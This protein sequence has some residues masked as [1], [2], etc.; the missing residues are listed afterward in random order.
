MTTNPTATWN[1]QNEWKTVVLMSLGFGLVGI[2]RF[3]LLPM[4]PV[5]AK[6]LGL[7]Y[8]D[9]GIIAGAL[10]VTW[11][12]TAIFIG[13][14]A[15]RFGRRKV[16]IY[17]LIVFSVLVGLSG[18]AAGAGSL[19]VLRAVMGFAEGAYAPA[20]I[21]ATLEASKPS[22]HG[23]NLGFQQ[24]A[25][26]LLGLG[27]APIVVTQLLH[28]VDWRWIF[29]LVALPGFLL[30]YLVFKVLRD[31]DPKELALHTATHDANEH[32]WTDVLK[33]RNIPL[34]MIGMLCWLTVLMVT[35]A[36][37]PNYLTDYLHLEVQ[38]MGF[39]LSAIGVGAAVGTVVM[40]ALSD[41]IGRKPVMVISVLCALL[42]LWLL[43]G[44]GPEPGKLFFYLFMTNFFN[45]ACICLTVGPI[46]AESVPVKLMA[47]GSGLVIGVGELFGGAVMPSLAGFVAKH[48][49]IQY[50]MD[51][52]LGGLAVGLIVA[53]SL[54][55]TAP[56]RTRRAAV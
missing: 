4:F 18:L 33:Y 23:M 32:K 14:I 8:Q 28:V 9:M 49:G 43:K 30:A 26:P 47:T 40:P 22:R 44:T 31:H 27:L 48:Y 45:F 52:A 5:I 10:A 54:K 2:D 7:D 15:D 12:L 37:L 25:L 19:I 42:F 35:T 29:V 53:L 51:L 11:G 17:A 34:M 24:A 55:E 3:M 46:S 20:A 6:E 41:R 50:I 21:T 38:Q 36:L 39:V 1:V 13:N 16:L 56:S